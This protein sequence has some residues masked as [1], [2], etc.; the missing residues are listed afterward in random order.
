MPKDSEWELWVKGSGAISFGERF[1]QKRTVQRQ[2]KQ[3]AE[4]GGGELLAGDEL[5]TARR[6]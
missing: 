6:R 5:G 1:K 4:G 2:A 3:R